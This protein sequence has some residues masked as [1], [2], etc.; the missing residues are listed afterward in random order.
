MY[1]VLLVLRNGV[2]ARNTVSP[3]RKIAALPV[4]SVLLTCVRWAQ[5]YTT[6]QATPYDMFSEPTRA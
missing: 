1:I 6:P 4:Q 2:P 3:F 5:S